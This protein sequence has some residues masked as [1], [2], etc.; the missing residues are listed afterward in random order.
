M[1]TVYYAITGWNR[2]GE[3]ALVHVERENGK[4]KKET[5]C[6]IFPDQESAETE[7]N[8]RNERLLGG[9]FENSD[10]LGP[11]FIPNI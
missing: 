11:V 6:Q 5:L 1:I 3:V 7:M 8:S 10:L 4:L 2:E 9:T